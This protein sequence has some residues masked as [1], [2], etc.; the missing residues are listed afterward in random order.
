VRRKI[1]WPKG[2]EITKGWRKLHNMEFH[3]PYSSPENDVVIKLRMRWAGNV[4]CMEKNRNLYR[5]LVRK[6]ENRRRFR[7]PRNIMTNNIKV[8]LKEVDWEDV[9]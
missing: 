8:D 5:V 3:D 7:R 6:P 4:A 1:F 9:N 2:E